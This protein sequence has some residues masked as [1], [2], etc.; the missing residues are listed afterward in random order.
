MPKSNCSEWKTNTPGTFSKLYGKGLLKK[1]NYGGGRVFSQEAKFVAS[2]QL[3]FLLFPVL[4]LTTLCPSGK[5][6]VVN[7]RGAAKF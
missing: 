1:K 5:K 4:A 3:I 6:S 7:G 2:Y